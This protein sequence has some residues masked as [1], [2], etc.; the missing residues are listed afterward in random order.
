MTPPP[1]SR[2]NADVLSVPLS[3]G[4]AVLPRWGRF[5]GA[6]LFPRRTIGH[7]GAQQFA[8]NRVRTQRFGMAKKKENDRRPNE[9]HPGG[10]PPG[11]PG[12]PIELT[13]DVVEEY[14]KALECGLSIEE[15]A[16]VIDVHRSSVLRAAE[17]NE[18]LAQGIKRAEAKGKY[19]HLKKIRDG[20]DTWQPSAWMLAR[21]WWRE[22]GPRNPDKFTAKDVVDVVTS[23]LNALLPYIPEKHRQAAHTAVNAALVGV[24][25]EAEQK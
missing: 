20:D 23:V 21:K 24:R 4:P 2:Y 11:V 19:H 13:D 25:E 1:A 8:R 9:R 22:Y 18:I 3:A 10:R 12:T 6:F 16:D 15:A 5:G 7:D 14:L 17:K